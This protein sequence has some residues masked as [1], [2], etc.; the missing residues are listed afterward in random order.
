MD[1]NGELSN[2]ADKTK[3]RSFQM[4]APNILINLFIFSYFA[5]C[6]TLFLSPFERTIR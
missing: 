6:N 2:Y 1:P 4:K 3:K 5:N